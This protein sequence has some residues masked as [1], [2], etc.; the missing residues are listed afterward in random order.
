MEEVLGK[1]AMDILKPFDTKMVSNVENKIIV[2][3]HKCKEMDPQ[4]VLGGCFG[5][6]F[7]CFNLF[8]SVRHLLG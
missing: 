1:P 7:Y 5:G 6:V 4:G 2:H 3:I 8:L